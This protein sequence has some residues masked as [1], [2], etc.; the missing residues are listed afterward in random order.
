MNI[1]GTKRSLQKL[2]TATSKVL[3]SFSLDYE[4][5]LQIA[6]ERT[7]YQIQPAKTFNFQSCLKI[8]SFAD[9]LQSYIVQSFISIFSYLGPMDRE[10]TGWVRTVIGF[11]LNKQKTLSP[12]RIHSC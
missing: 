3:I 2:L 1:V 4:C 11:I 10:E 7:V 5:L 8:P 6:T 12:S 9:S